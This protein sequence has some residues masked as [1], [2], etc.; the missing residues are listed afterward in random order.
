MRLPYMKSTPSR[1]KKQ[2]ITFGGV[3]YS[4]DHGDGELME[5]CGL[6]SAQF[7]CLCQRAGR[8]TAGSYQE[9]TGLYARGKLCVVEGTD[10]LYGGEVV[11]Q[12]TAGEKQ[13]A[14]INT[15]IV[16]FPDKAY[17][18]TEAGVLNYNIV[19]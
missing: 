2:I 1:S 9:P 10:F 12:V 3:N 6:S 4:Q 17:Y 14:T 15:K 11:G 8:K 7:P 16:I 13:F 5:S 18:D 19:E